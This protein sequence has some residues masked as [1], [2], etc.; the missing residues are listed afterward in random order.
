MMV[1]HDRWLLLLLVAVSGVRS[2]ILI[3]IADSLLIKQWI[4]TFAMIHAAV[5]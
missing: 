2:A 5:V 4:G 1:C 3:A